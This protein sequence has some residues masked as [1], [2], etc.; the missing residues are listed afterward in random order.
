[1]PISVSSKTETSVNSGSTSVS[2]TLKEKDMS[3][4]E[5]NKNSSS[6]S[7]ETLSQAPTELNSTWG[8]YG[9]VCRLDKPCLVDEIHLRRFDGLLVVIDY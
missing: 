4:G 7:H 9:K 1:M 8:I 6:S 3:T 2:S 5:L